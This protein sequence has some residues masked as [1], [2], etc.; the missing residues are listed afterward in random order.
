[1]LKFYCGMID[2]LMPDF[3]S[4][5][6]DGRER[7]KP[8]K[9][10]AD[11]VESGDLKVPHIGSKDFPYPFVLLHIIRDPGHLMQKIRG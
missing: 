11:V 10:M 5:P 9:E 4:R 2:Q 6:T 1:M 7:E 3:V 8:A